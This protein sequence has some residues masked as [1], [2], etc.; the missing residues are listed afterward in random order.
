MD[1]SVF[2][3]RPRG[4]ATPAH[5][6]RD[7]EAE[8]ERLRE[9]NAR[10]AERAETLTAIAVMLDHRNSV[11]SLILPTCPISL[12]T[13][14]DQYEDEDGW[15]VL[16]VRSAAGV[17]GPCG[18]VVILNMY[19]KWQ[20]QAPDDQRECCPGCLQKIV[21]H[22]AL[23]VDHGFA[24]NMTWAE[25][26]EI[27]KNS[28]VRLPFCL[29]ALEPYITVARRQRRDVP[30][31]LTEEALRTFTD[32]EMDLVRTFMVSCCPWI[33]TLAL[34]LALALDW[35]S[36]TLCPSALVPTESLLS[37]RPVHSGEPAGGAG[38]SGEGA[39]S[40]GGRGRSRGWTGG[41]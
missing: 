35:H 29:A 9:E 30:V 32:R 31:A 6:L 34:A 13:L 4:E 28:A 36:L 27:A 40:S 11:M 24:P 3:H 14:M 25:A 17:E 23:R 12:M 21:G 38:R 1:W 33:A 2:V 7:L 26:L 39:R 22:F 15:V 19:V 18:H 5:L 37:G 16:V 41:G 20:Q 10:L 8:N